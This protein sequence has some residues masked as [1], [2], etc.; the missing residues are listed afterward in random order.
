MEIERL[1]VTQ[2]QFD[3][4]EAAWEIC[5]N[6]RRSANGEWAKTFDECVREVVGRDVPASFTLRVSAAVA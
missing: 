4:I 1:Y 6:G 2:A 5:S 3:R